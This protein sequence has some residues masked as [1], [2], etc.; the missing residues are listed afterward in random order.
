MAPLS[1]TVWAT[2][3]TAGHL[4]AGACAARAGR[5]ADRHHDRGRRR[6]TR[7]TSTSCTPP[8]RTIPPGTVITDA[9]IGL[10]HKLAKRLG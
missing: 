2:T 1:E 10:L 4:S 6:I 5:A 8:G 7:A 9:A 3:F